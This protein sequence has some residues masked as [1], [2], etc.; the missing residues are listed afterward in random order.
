MSR[1]KG[2]AVVG[3]SGGPTAAINASL[4]GVIRGVLS[5]ADAI[6]AL[7]GTDPGGGARLLSEETARSR[8]G[9]GVLRRADR[10][11]P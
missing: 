4:A 6:P 9:Q 7:S 11:V 1:L 5:N 3:Q 2:N 10:K 8:K